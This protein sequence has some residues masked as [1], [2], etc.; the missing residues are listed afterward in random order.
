M[1]G[2][3]AKCVTSARTGYGGQKAQQAVSQALNKGNKENITAPAPSSSST[4]KSARKLKDYK[5]EYQ[6]LQRKLRHAT[7]YKNK[8]K[9]AL[10]VYK[11]RAE[12]SEKAVEAAR[13]EA[14]CREESLQLAV[15]K[16]LAS[17]EQK[18]ADLKELVVGPIDGRWCPSA[19]GSETK[20]KQSARNKSR[21]AL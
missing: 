10:D 3:C 20:M 9:A 12:D 18:A 7:T 4:S 21:S 6:N 16:A 13:Q 5:K 8:L 2:S 14:K 1:P 17:G 15:A 11:T 19:A